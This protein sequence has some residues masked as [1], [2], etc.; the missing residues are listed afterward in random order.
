MLR[1]FAQAPIC[2]VSRWAEIDAGVGVCRITVIGDPPGPAS[3][4]PKITFYVRDGGNPGKGH[5]LR[6]DEARRCASNLQIGDVVRLIG[7]IGPE[8]VKA[9]RQE[10]V[11][12]EE[13]KL[14]VRAPKV[15]DETDEEGDDQVASPEDAEPVTDASADGGGR[16]LAVE[17]PA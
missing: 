15:E 2:E 8:R 12:T 14:K 3:S 10:V 9:G 17:V 6:P 16:V 13:V 11:V 1:T 4:P 7:D 5:P